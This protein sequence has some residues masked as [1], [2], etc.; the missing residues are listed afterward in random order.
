[1]SWRPEGWK[2]LWT[3]EEIKNAPESIRLQMQMCYD[4]GADDMLKALRKQGTHVEKLEFP[5]R[6]PEWRDYV[7]NKF[8][9]PAKNGRS[10][11]VIFIPDEE[12]KP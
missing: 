6:L 1:M 5:D 2:P 3:E 4:E 9:I 7:G 8:P 10:G 12:V 11:F